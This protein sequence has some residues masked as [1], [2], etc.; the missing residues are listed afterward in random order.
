MVMPTA[1]AL[2][3][4]MLIPPPAPDRLAA[5]AELRQAAPL[6]DEWQSWLMDQSATR[7][8]YR[9]FGPGLPDNYAKVSAAKALIASRLAAQR[10]QIDGHIAGCLDLYLGRAFEVAALHEMTA[11]V[12][13]KGGLLLWWQAIQAP[14][15]TCYD[16]AISDALVGYFP[17][18]SWLARHDMLARVPRYDAAKGDS[19]FIRDIESLCGSGARGVVK[20]R[21]GGFALTMRFFEREG[22][23]RR[24]P[25]E[26]YMCVTSAAAAAGY[27]L[28]VL[29]K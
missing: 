20:S 17:A 3:V 25:T 2:A 29:D 10:P 6:T 7:V 19:A 27:R 21:P 15:Q 24:R 4:A 16:K 9:A 12:A 18:I 1:I 13:T 14:A 5:A 23:R 22:R 8:A 26:T 11:A 28:S